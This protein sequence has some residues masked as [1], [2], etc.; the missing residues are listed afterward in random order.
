MAIHEVIK[1]FLY[2]PDGI[3]RVYAMPGDRLEMTDEAAKSLAA[4]LGPVP[5]P[6]GLAERRAVRSGKFDRHGHGPGDSA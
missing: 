1:S 5:A 4:Y 3:Y 2:S 6:G